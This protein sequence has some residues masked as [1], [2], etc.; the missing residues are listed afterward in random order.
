M[1][2]IKARNTCRAVV[3]LSTDLPTTPPV[4]RVN[5]N[6]NGGHQRRELD[7]LMSARARSGASRPCFSFS[8]LLFSES[9]TAIVVS[10][11]SAGVGSLAPTLPLAGLTPPGLGV[12]LPPTA[13]KKAAHHLHMSPA[14][15]PE[16]NPIEIN[17]EK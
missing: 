5:R 17:D 14:V 1:D 13:S 16:N 10:L 12:S 3:E 9:T 15:S 8:L 2:D 11:C 7:V 4:L 6:V